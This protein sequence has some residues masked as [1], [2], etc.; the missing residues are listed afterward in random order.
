M[1]PKILG[2]IPARAGSQGV[3]GK[4]TKLLGS[5]SLIHYTFQSAIQSRLL[6]T[7]ALSTDSDEIINAAKSFPDIEI[8]FVRPAN[9]AT[10][11]TPTVL[12]I[13]HALNFYQ[14]IGQ[15]FDYVCLLQAT[16]PFRKD[17]L[18]DKAVSYF[19]HTN[20]ESLTTVRRVPS[21][22]NPHWC[23]EFNENA[24]LKPVM[25][26]SRLIL[27]RQ[28]LPDA[29]YRD[30]QIYIVSRKLVQ[31]GL[32][33][34]EQTIGLINNE[35]PDINIDTIDDWNLAKKWLSNEK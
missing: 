17:G 11:E 16:T 22:Y 3:P 18:I 8:P 29:Y 27:R 5:K 32:L 4:H 1:A 13:Q 10:D 15:H 20:A 7:V 28:D 12:V 34:N 9:L 6:D 14:N 30:G 26:E 31:N 35:G 21:K 2:L 24:Q 19:L 25:Q 23:F 33:L